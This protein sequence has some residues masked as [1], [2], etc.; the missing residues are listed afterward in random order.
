MFS[1]RGRKIQTHLKII[2]YPT[3]STFSPEN[4]PLFLAGPTK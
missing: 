2:G 3:L 4:L 1:M